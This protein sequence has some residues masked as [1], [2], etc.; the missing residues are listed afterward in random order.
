MHHVNNLPANR[1]MF[2]FCQFSKFFKL[3]IRKTD[4]CSFSHKNQYSPYIIAYF[5]III[6]SSVHIFKYCYGQ[7]NNKYYYNVLIHK[8]IYSYD[9]PICIYGWGTRK[10]NFLIKASLPSSRHPS[11]NLVPF[12]SYLLSLKR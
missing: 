8:F 1:S 4:C 2:L 10:M 12:H 7:I 9:I 6:F 3:R 5:N 11:K